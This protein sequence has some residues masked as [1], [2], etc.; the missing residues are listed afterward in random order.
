VDRVNVGFAAL[1]MNEDLGFSPQIFGFGAGLFFI[2]YFLFEVPSNLILDRVGASRWIARI[3]VT[4]GLMSMGM[5]FVTGPISFYVLRFLLGVAEAGFFPGVI[6]FLTRWCPA[7]YRSRIIAIFMVAIPASLAVAAPL[8]TAILSMDGI[9]GLR[10]WQW[11]FVLEGAPTIVLALL[12]LRMLPD[13]PDKARWLRPDQ[14]RWLQDRLHEERQRLP[15]HHKV[16]WLGALYD[17]RVLVLAF[18]YFA[19]TGTNLGL[20]FF[21]PQI[22]R[23][24]GVPTVYNGL[25][26]M[27]PY[28]VGIAAMLVS[29]RI[30]DRS[31]NRP[32]M[33]MAALALT[34]VGLAGAGLLRTSYF[35][36][37]LMSIAAAGLYG[38]KAPFWPLPSMFLGG[39]AAAS[40]IAFIN[41]IGNLGGFVGPYMV[42]WLRGQTGSFESGLYGLAAL[43][44]AGAVVTLAVR[45]EAPAAAAANTPRSSVSIEPGSTR[46]GV[47]DEA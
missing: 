34:A 9:W 47:P 32:L 30:C 24:L 3:M 41:S 11:L 21:L 37:V 16:D 19:N 1:T 40:G 26:T 29:G 31:G 42:G 6:L 7:A 27:I 45:A 25:V 44:L 36:I 18:I 43:S 28:V 12:V 22:V 33:L 20:A 14:R 17:K 23:D 8:S 15:A 5:V 46:S 13:N 4:W 2:G 38:A 10:G 35:S 39:A